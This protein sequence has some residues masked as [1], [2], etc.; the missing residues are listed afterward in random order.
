MQ[1][2]KSI[3]SVKLGMNRDSHISDLKGNEYS[4]LLNGNTSSEIGEGIN[5][6]NEPSNYLGVVFPENY[7][8]IGFRNDIL[9]ERTYYFLTNPTTR[10]SSI[11][12]VDNVIVETFNN[13]VEQEC[14]DCNYT[15]V[16]GVPLETVIQTPTLEYVEL[17]NDDCHID[18]GREGLNFN[19]NFPA[20]KIEIKQEKLGTTLYW[21]D[22]RNPK[23]YINVTNIEENPTSHYLLTQEVP[24][25][26]DEIVDCILVDKL[27]AFPKHNKIQ[28]EAETIQTGGNLK[29]GTYEFYAVYCDLLGNEIVNYSTPTNPI[30]IFD[31]NNNILSQT[32]TDAFTNFAIKL[33]VKNL[34]GRAFKYYKV[35]C[36]ER[37]NVDNTQSAFVEGIHPT[38][39]DTIVYT[40]SGSSVDDNITR[41]NVSI[42]RRID[43]STLNLVKPNY[44][45]A[46]GTMVSGGRM[47]DYGLHKR[48]ELNLQPVVNLFSA[49]AEWQTSAAK[50]D[51]YKSAIATSKYKGYMRNEVQ[52]FGLRFFYKDGDYSAVFPW[53]GRPANSND[54]ETVSDTNYDSI[55]ANTPAC[56]VNERDKRWQ[57]FNTATITSNCSETSEG[58]TNI[59]TLNKSCKI[60]NIAEIPADTI[61]ISLDVPFTGL[62]DFIA[63]NP[64]VYIPE[65]TPYLEEDYPDHCEP[66]F[67]NNCDIAVLVDS[68]NE[69]S[70]ILTSVEEIVV[71]N[72]YLIEEVEE[73][74]NFSNIGFKNVDEPFV[75]INTTPIDWTNGTVVYSTKEITEY[76]DKPIDEYRRASAPKTC[77][78][79]KRNLSTGAYIRD[80]EFE[81]AFMPCYDTS[82]RKKVYE[83]DS[84]FTNEICSQAEDIL[85][86][87]LAGKVYFLNYSGDT[88]EAN[89]LT[90]Y[91]VSAPTITA[92]FKNKLHK[93][94]LFFKASKNSRDRLILDITKN[95][96]CQDDADELVNLKLL[97][98][99]IYKSCSDF[100]VLG[101]GIIDTA[102]G[103]FTELDVSSFPNTFLIAIDAPITTE[104]IE[105]TCS[106]FPIGDNTVYKIV[107]PCGCFSIFTRDI[108]YSEVEVTWT[109]IILD[110]FEKYESECTF[111]IPNV[112]ECKPEPYVKGIFAYWESTESYPDNKQ[113]YDSSV[114]KIK[115]SDLST[116]LEDKKDN[117]LQYFTEG[118]DI[119]GDGN[120]I[121]KESTNLTCKP[122]RHPKFPDNTIAPFM[123]DS[124]S[125]QKFSETIIFPLG[126][127]IDPT[128]IT[129]LLQVARNN[130]LITQ[131]ELENIEGYEIL[132][133]DNTV[134]K[135]VIANG[136]GFDMYNYTK[137]GGEKWWYSNFPFNDLGNDKFHTSDSARSNLIKHPNNG[138]SNHLFTFLSPDI[139]LTK[140]AL[141]TEVV[142]AGYQFGNSSQSI[143]DVKD[144]PKFTILGKDARDLS[145]TLGIA[146]AA[147]EIAAKIAEFVTQ[148]GTGNLWFVGGFT[149]GTNSPGAG[150][151]AA[152]IG[153]FSGVVTAQGFVKVGQYRYEWLK[154]FRDLGS[155]Y[156][157]ASMGV[158]VGTYNRFLKTD[159][160]G[161][162]Y[163]RGLSVKKYIKDDL[164]N[165]VDK[166]DGTPLNINNWLREDTALLSTGS[167]FKFNYP[168]DYKNRDNNKVNSLSSKVL[169][170]DINCQ[171]NLNSIRDIASPYFSLK[172]YIPDQW[173]NVDSVKWLTTNYFFKV[174]DETDCQP[175]FG[176]TVCISPFSW[177]RKTPHFRETAFNQPD[178]T[179]FSYSEYNN[180]AYSKFYVDY[181]NDTQYNGLLIPFP[182]IDSD[183][184]F[185]CETGRRGFYVRPPS[186]MYLYSY[187]IVNF[188]VESEINCHFRY[189]KRGV[190]DRVSP[191]DG[192]Y[193][194]ISNVAEWVQ[195]K[196]MPI[197]KPNTFYYNNSY[198]FPVSNTSYKFL[199]YTYDK[200]IWRKRNEQPN[201]VIYSEIDNNENS[202]TDPWL[203]FKSLNFYEFSSKFGK[204]IDLKDIESSQFLARFEN[205]LVLHNAIDNLAD[206][207]TP[208]NKEL[209]TGGIFASR[210]LEFKTTDLGFQGT[211]NTDMSSTPYGHFWVDAKRGRAF[212]LDQNGKNAEVISE[213]VGNK[214]TNMKQ[215]FRE[216]LPF[217][218]LKTFPQADIDNKFKGLGI[219]IGYDDRKSRIFFTKK[220]YITKNNP[221]LKY[222]EE[223]GF[224][225][226]CQ[227]EEII[228]PENYT[229]NP[230]TQMC[231]LVTNSDNLCPTGYSY[232][233]E[234][235]TCTLIEV[236]EAECDPPINFDVTSTDWGSLTTSD[237][238]E[239]YFL[240]Q[241]ASIA[242]VSNFSLI[243]GRVQFFVNTDVTDILLTSKN[244][245]VVNIID[246][247]GL[248]DLTL[249]DNLISVFDPIVPLP[250]TLQRLSFATNSIV[251]FNPTLP[252]PSTLLNLQLL[253]NNIIV[254]NPTIALPNSL[255]I[256]NLAAN[257]IV[258]FNPTLPLPNSLKDLGLSTN[259]ITTFNPTLPLPSNL[260]K[261][262][263]NVNE[264]VNFN[265]TIALPNSLQELY[266]QGNDLSVFNPTLALPSSLNTLGLNNN[267]NIESSDWNSATSWIALAPNSVTLSAD[268]SI[269]GTTTESLL[270]SKSW[271]INII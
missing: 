103:V 87:G 215:W 239:T 138:N 194:Q 43:L 68:Y 79:Y 268:V 219:S 83:R 236:Y 114:L 209:G 147:L 207:I 107:P 30:S 97:R 187:G 21:N 265:P 133:G 19:I 13:D 230:T 233:E 60:E 150:I 165:T 3:S 82:R 112:N 9:K 49:L 15:N 45:R 7:K 228:C 247:D 59:E 74:D 8:T 221:C 258:N 73:G 26:D 131:K 244:I 129:T 99:T 25:E 218:I 158:G 91:N 171:S 254:F 53:V 210:P 65:I 52:P 223:I 189:A 113:L 255:Q 28:I 151:S 81:D 115:P 139:F 27:L 142:L 256:L 6:Q 224:Y 170:S 58:V 238:W 145:L 159:S 54:L 90:T 220:D 232:N 262:R 235:G 211:Q 67:G 201:A 178:K 140:P 66:N 229:Y 108:E 100:T 51:L 130:G 188:L 234:L 56:G 208:Q 253:L 264:I 246:I 180:I 85:N 84:D 120:Y 127:N 173:G 242:T 35:V 76:L 63:D 128:I 212:Q 216:H 109:K 179:P 227:E 36:V 5:I 1:H 190:E 71:G 167:G 125:Q 61:I 95:S 154:I 193:P 199:D 164:Y 251:N 64:D 34:D 2:K 86:N 206:R 243:S 198:T 252:L 263:L 121:L 80:S 23:R 149:N 126:L 88:V 93:K 39:D 105:D 197:S 137:T 57:I 191:E 55:S 135:S 78:A 32:Q 110:K 46:K 204:L 182:D 176:G 249:N 18:A 136:L 122:I 269:V 195:E 214:P 237:S 12:Y 161:T 163:L 14:P 42:K 132:R 168:D 111:S 144:H 116:L 96:D 202:L 118:G 75:A 160:T 48:E 106:P 231:E 102:Q 183:Y 10:K 192:F 31:E 213:Q 185:D 174:T 259:D 37:N 196:N 172:N 24:C 104:S 4:F 222:D 72:Q 177:R 141:P 70:I 240:S 186:K 250:N 156:N 226:D 153:V 217:K 123:Y 205:Q 257:D 38:T 20:K 266:L 117:F 203:V 260:Q 40:H 248:I 175:I 16:L 261:L 41:G 267:I 77:S 143:V 47:F 134:H 69:I 271:T 270:T 33:K 17:I 241:G 181:E 162:E 50:E 146:E 152:A 166:S 89:L 184:K 94:A 98:Y 155:K 157:F 119:D 29:M 92:N 124:E 44:D 22:N 200:E 11:G 169:A 245:T 148:G 225:D 101:G 62:E